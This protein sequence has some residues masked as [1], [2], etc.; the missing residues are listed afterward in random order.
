MEENQ[1][2]FGVFQD[3]QLYCFFVM[4]ATI[5]VQ[6]LNCCCY[7]CLHAGVAVVKDKQIRRTIHLQ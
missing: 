5:F 2:F 4:P 7:K 6:Q 3:E 1:I